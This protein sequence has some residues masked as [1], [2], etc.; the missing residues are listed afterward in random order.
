MV[1][2]PDGQRAAAGC[3]DKTIDLWDITTGKQL[4][5]APGHEGPVFTLAL[6]KNG[7]TLASASEDGTVRL[8]D[9]APWADDPHDRGL[10]NPG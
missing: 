7:K 8:W 6:T 1:V 4:K 2:F 5:A 10:R 3:S 9:V